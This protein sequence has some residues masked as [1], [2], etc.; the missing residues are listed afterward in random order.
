MQQSGW[1][2]S[3]A[4]AALLFA[5]NITLNLPLF[6]AGE[7][8][9]RDSIEGGY[10]SMARFIAAHPNPWGWN[11]TQYCGLP[12]QFTYLPLLHYTVAAA[13]A[14][15]PYLEIEHVYRLVTVVFTL[16]GPS[17]LFL[18]VLSF[19]GSRRWAFATA[20][21]YTLF[22]P[23]YGLISQIDHDRGLVQLPWRLQV[24]AKYGEGP[25]NATLMLLPLTVLALWRAAV[26]G[27]FPSVFAAALL[28]AVTALTNWVGALALA[29]L[30]LVLVLIAPLHSKETGFQIAPILRASAIGYGLSCFWLTPSF[31]Q[32][33][34]FNWPKDAFNYQLRVQQM[35]FMAG[36]AA[37]AL[38]VWL[39]CRLLCRL[40]YL[41][42]LLLSFF[43]FAWVVLGYYW[44]GTDTIPESRRYALEFEMFLL[45]LLFEALRQI[46]RTGKGYLIYPALALVVLC[47]STGVRQVWRYATSDPLR[48]RPTA[49]E[50]TTEYEAG[51]WLAG[52]HTQGRVYASGG[53]RFRLNSWFETA[54]VGGTFETGLRNRVPLDFAYQIRTG[55]GSGP[56]RD[57]EDAVQQLTA[58]GVEYVIVHG[59][60]SDEYYRDFAR[61]AKFKGLLEEVWSQRDDII[62][63]LP[64]TSLAHLVR[65]EEL[66]PRPPVAGGLQYLA[67]YSAALRDPARPQLI[68]AWD[69][70]SRLRLSGPIPEDMLISVAVNFDEGWAASQDGRSIPSAASQLGFLLLHAKASP[71]SNIVLEYCGTVEQRMMALLSLLTWLACV[72][73]LW[74]RRSPLSARISD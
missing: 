35:S 53:L 22:S 61:P 1:R 39:L 72:Y 15:I 55:I 67:A 11:P 40:P 70:P 71:D 26:S 60:K 2:K 48:W 41:C 9:F 33:I 7:L 8:P 69:G 58:L 20:L 57:G 37:G 34:I 25:H 29:W 44:F 62:Y 46:L 4:L 16:L 38:L 23:V 66:P 24:L 54:Q 30:V 6:Q 56:G 5:I 42:F 64:F 12:T 18:F 10:A 65:R 63:R 45:L 73:F 32:T 52:R 68:S 50:F 19:T 13:H 27:R 59:P 43:G 74:K 28:L 51:S 17:I 49:K 47:Y 36:F 3:V 14:V 31:V 21:T